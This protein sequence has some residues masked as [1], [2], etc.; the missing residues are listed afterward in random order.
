MTIEKRRHSRI[1][2][3]VPVS[4]VSIDSRGTPLNY[5]MGVIRNLSQSGAAIEVVTDVASDYLLLSF[6]D[7][8][9]KTIEIKAKVMHS[10]KTDSGKILIGIMF[11]GFSQNNLQFITKLVRF[12]NITKKR[13]ASV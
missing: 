3:P 2:L 9:Q 6:V 5:N 7:T 10:S 4:C 1:K 13:E 8:D 12:Y 11:L